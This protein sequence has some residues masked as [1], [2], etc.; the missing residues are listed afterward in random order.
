MH[1]VVFCDH[2]FSGGNWAL[3]RRVAGGSNWNIAN[4][5]LAGTASYNNYTSG[6]SSPTSFSTSYSSFVSGPSQEFLFMSGDKSIFM[7]TTWGQLSAISPYPALRL[8]SS[9]HL[10]P[11]PQMVYFLN[12]GP[13]SPS[14]PILSLNTTTIAGPVLYAEGNSSANA[15]LLSLG[16]M[17][18]YIRSEAF[19]K[20][21]CKPGCQRG[22]C[23]LPNE[24][25]CI[26]HWTGDLCDSCDDGWTGAN[27]SKPICGIGCNLIAATCGIPDT[28]SC[29]AGWMGDN[30]TT[31]LF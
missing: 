11:G 28:C 6:S 22:Y 2:G 3:V 20:A 30:C 26:P 25:T 1:L 9:S 21:P 14:D 12:R 19:C 29:N 15:S 24:C 31:R 27:C 10:N 13:T 4:D 5:D 18:V 23:T 17:D 7:I 8:V 16:G